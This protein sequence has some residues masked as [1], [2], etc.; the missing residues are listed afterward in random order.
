M[1][2]LLFIENELHI[3]IKEG[4]VERDI[5]AIDQFQFSEHQHLLKSKLIRRDC[6]NYSIIQIVFL[7]TCPDKRGSVRFY[8]GKIL[9]IW[10][11]FIGIPVD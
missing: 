6:Q 10:I 8:Y 11:L 9:L 5:G 4:T 7:S 3:C 2:S 1:Q